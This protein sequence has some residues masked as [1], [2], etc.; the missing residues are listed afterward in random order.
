MDGAQAFE[1]CDLNK[2]G[3]LSFDEFKLWYSTQ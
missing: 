1:D 3:R 2:D